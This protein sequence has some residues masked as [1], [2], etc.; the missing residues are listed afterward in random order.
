VHRVV[1]DGKASYLSGEDEPVAGGDGS[2]WTVWGNSRNRSG[3]VLRVTTDGQRTL[4]PNFTGVAVAPDKQIWGTKDLDPPVKKGGPYGELDRLDPSGTATFVSYVPEASQIT[5][6]H[7]GSVYGRADSAHVLW[8]WSPDGAVR[9]F[10]HVARELGRPVVAADG[11]L[12]SAAYIG[13]SRWLYRI[14]PSTNAIKAL[15]LPVP[16]FGYVTATKGAVWLNTMN[17]ILR[18][19]PD[20]RVKQFEGPIRQKNVEYAIAAPGA[21]DTLWVFTS[22]LFPTKTA[23]I[24]RF[25]P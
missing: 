3:G 22:Q 7:D 24:F 15:R 21:N 5:F 20:G 17:G 10:P 4:F 23:A 8:R 9:A 25:Q 19:N 14:D 11:I 13:V 12:W 18:V 1:L 2:L 16:A 6:G